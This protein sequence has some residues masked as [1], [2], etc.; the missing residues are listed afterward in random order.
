MK[1]RSLNEAEV[2]FAAGLVA[3]SLNLTDAECLVEDT[4]AVADLSLI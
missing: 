1:V 2:L 4:P 3:L